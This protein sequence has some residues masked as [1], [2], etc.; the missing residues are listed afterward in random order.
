MRSGHLARIFGSLA[1]IA[2][3]S[4]LADQKSSGSGFAIADGTRIVTANHVVEGCTSI[5]IPDVGAANIVKSE[6]RSDLAIIRPNRPLAIARGLQFRSGHSVKL[7][8]EIVVIGYPLRGLLSSSP[9]VTIGTVS[10]LAGIGDDR[11]QMHIS[12]P[13]QPGNSGGPVLDRSGNVV[14]MVESKLDTIKAAELTGDI[15]QN[16]N[17][18]IHSVIITSFLDSYA[19]NYDVG[20]SDKE[21]PV[22]EIAATALPSIVVIECRIE[23]TS[24]TASAIP[25]PPSRKEPSPSPQ[26]RGAPSEERSLQV[27]R[28]FYTALGKADGASASRLVIPEKRLKGAF[29]ASEINKFYSSLARPLRLVETKP[30]GVNMVEAE[31]QYASPDGRGCQGRAVVNLVVRGDELLIESIRALDRC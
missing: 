18:A 5:N 22:S 8:D 25:Q 23:K 26:F 15:A 14:G 27:V 31:Y 28:A 9:T 30:E 19:I 2:S 12:A 17:F 24:A 3:T 21:R 16:I 13:V 10:S 11:T 1:L 7:G 20:K 6:P 4:A 29:A